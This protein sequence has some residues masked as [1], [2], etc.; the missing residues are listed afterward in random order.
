MVVVIKHREHTQ[1]TPIRNNHT[2]YII[3]PP[4][5]S[6]RYLIIIIYYD[7][8]IA[9]FPHARVTS[10]NI[11]M[12]VYRVGT[13]KNHGKPPADGC[14]SPTILRA[15]TADDSSSCRIVRICGRRRSVSG[16]ELLLLLLHIY[17][18]MYRIIRAMLHLSGRCI[19]MRTGVYIT[20][21]R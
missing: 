15:Y 8:R 14:G 17:I 9:R 2:T 12:V 4:R 6:S 11:N 3:M 5:E 13:W 16:I 18:M 7:T 19:R 1:H 10:Q 20:M 21:R